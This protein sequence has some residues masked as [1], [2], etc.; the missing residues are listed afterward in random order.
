MLLLLNLLELLLACLPISFIVFTLAFLLE[1]FNTPL[2][3]GEHERL[4]A[5]RARSK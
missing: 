4:M 2:T 3:R 1:W 5:F